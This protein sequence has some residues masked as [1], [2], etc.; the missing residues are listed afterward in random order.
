LHCT[1]NNVY[2]IFN[3]R[4][5]DLQLLSTMS[6]I[7]EYDLLAECQNNSQPKYFVAIEVDDLK[8]K[9]IQSDSLIKILYAKSV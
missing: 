2:S 9:E 1:R 5:I 3:R 6:E 8:M 4:N 7:L